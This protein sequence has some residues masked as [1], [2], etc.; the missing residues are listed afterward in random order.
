VKHL[1]LTQRL[2]LVFAVLLIAC[3]GVSVWLQIKASNRHE[4]E[5]VQ[6][7][8]TGLAA[9]IA[10]TAQLMDVGGWR[11]DAV[12]DLFDKLMAVNPSVEVYLLSRD[13][14]IVGNAAPEG[15]VKLERVDLAPIKRLLE[16]APLP[17]LGADPRNPQAQKVFSAAPVTV[18]GR[19]A[20]Y[21]YVVLQGEA[22]EALA[23]ALSTDSV[24][25]PT[26]WAMALMALFTLIMGLVAFRLITRPLRQLTQAV[27]NFDPHGE[28]AAA[29]VDNQAHAVHND[30]IGTLRAAFAQMG[31]RLTQQWRELSAQDQQRRDMV[32]NISHDLRTPLTSLHGYL[33]TLRVKDQALTADERRHYLDIALAQSGKVGRLAQ[34]LFELARLESGLVQPELEP[35]ALPDLVQD[36]MQK[37]E[38]AAEARQQRL[39]VEMAPALPAVRADLG[40]IE[41][42][43]TNLLD[44]AIRHNPPGT[45]IRVCMQVQSAQVQVEVAD[46]GQGLSPKAREGLF[47]RASALQRVPG[48]SGGLG[49]IIVQRMLQLH[50]SEVRL[51]EAN[52]P[53]TVFRFHLQ[54]A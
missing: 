52:Q 2:S 4:Q 38:L 8:S 19:E 45:Q 40:M 13:G 3:S 47:T 12:R 20:G 15:R 21:V 36:V 31:Q 46:S 5:V 44:N 32:A 42:V 11:P 37:F 23:A 30:E 18:D 10:A 43:L 7:L 25:R 34:E 50:N 53:G 26:L 27:G 1:S 28:A 14:K 16:G 24:L 35:F 48:E 6:E 41:R 33:E 49:L 9:H 51:V 29:L 17:V 22:R 39:T 54:A